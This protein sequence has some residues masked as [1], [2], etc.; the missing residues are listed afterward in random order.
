MEL[1]ANE[2]NSKYTKWNCRTFQLRRVVQRLL[3]SS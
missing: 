2:D 3:N 1:Q